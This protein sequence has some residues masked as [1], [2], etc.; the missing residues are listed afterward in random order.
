[1]F[2]AP[3]EVDSHGEVSVAAVRVEAVVPEGELHQGDVRRVHALQRDPGRA[4][5]PAGFCDQ[6]LQSLQ[7]LLQ[8]GS[9]DQASLKHGGGGVF[10]SA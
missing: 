3:A 8:D 10:K 5:V 6:V 2:A 4:H 9:L 7:D 1:M